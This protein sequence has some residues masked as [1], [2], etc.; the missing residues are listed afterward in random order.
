M[1]ESLIEGED[2]MNRAE[3]PF[4]YYLP[5]AMC[6]VSLLIAANI[7]AQKL[8]VVGPY[9]VTAASIIY[10]MTYVLADVFTEVYGYA[11][12]RQVI[13]GALFCNILFAVLAEVAILLPSAPIWNEQSQFAAIMGH[14]PQIVAASMVSYLVGEFMNAYVLAR[15]KV[16][17]KGKHLWMRTIGSTIVG[18][19]LDTVIFTG[20]AFYGILNGEQMVSLMI[21]MYILKVLYEVIV[22]PFVY[23]LTGFLKKRESIDVFDQEINFNPFAGLMRKRGE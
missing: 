17:T 1:S 8:I 11:Y 19:A 3:M 13:W 6:F 16:L 23:A 2:K 18:Q 5:L 12:S 22:T 7:L 21:T 15:M 20:I 9:N 14:T 10:P 4:R